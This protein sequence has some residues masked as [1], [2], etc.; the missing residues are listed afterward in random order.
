M[1]QLKA[2]KS[3][4]RSSRHLSR[5]SR[6]FKSILTGIFDKKAESV[7]SLD[8]RK[9]HEAVADFF[10]ICE[11]STAVQVK[12]IADS[13][14]D[15]VKADTGEIPYRVEGQQHGKWVLIDFVNVVVHVMHPEQRAFYQLEEMWSD[16]PLTEHT[17]DHTHP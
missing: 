3:D 4:S 10:V 15:K 16:A 6:L 1:S 7:V 9:I 13:V 8:L 11:A 14:Q 17:P 5:Q 2:T 12:A